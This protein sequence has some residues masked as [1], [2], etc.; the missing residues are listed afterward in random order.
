MSSPFDRIEKHLVEGVA[1][2][3]LAAKA[4]SEHGITASAPLFHRFVVLETIFDPSVVDEQKADYYRHTLGVNNVKLALVLPRNTIIGRRVLDGATSSATE[5]ALFLFPFFP[6]TIAMPCSPGDHVWVMFENPTERQTDIGYWFNKIVEPGFVDDVN[7]TH[8]PRILESTFNPGA[9]D[10][11]DGKDKAVYE[12]RNGQAGVRDGERFSLAETLHI[13][14]LADAYEKLMSDTEAGRLATYESIPRYKKR[15]NDLALEGTNN[16]LIVLGRDRT[17]PAATY[18][19][20]DTKGT[21]IVN[22]VDVN[23]VSIDTKGAGSI[24]MVVGR[25]QTSKTSGKKVKSKTVLKSEFHEELG[26]AKNE[27]TEH[28]GDVDLLNDRSRFLISQKTKAD[29]N[30]AID[31]VV[32]KHTSKLPIE[33]SVDGDG[34]IVIKTDKIRFVA[35]Q[36]IVILVTGSTE[37]DENGNVKDVEALPENCASVTMRVNGDIIFTPSTKGLIKLGGD[38][39]DKSVLCT[40]VNNKGVGGTIVST[41]I[42]DSM[43]GSQGGSDGLNGIFA[44]KVLLK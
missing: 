16:T 44:S 38:D 13:P 25:G 43:G 39:A 4:M 2:K 41:P 17:G 29:K 32:S 6:S 37:K 1:D 28:E 3:I 35:R 10:I 14:G 31:K 24:D 8:A 22:G 30:F 27:L 42:V 34:Y 12:F 26:K 18:K 20:G 36:D 7:H 23:D 15:P 40:T 33:Y 9:K 5:P 19:N 11:A 21:Q